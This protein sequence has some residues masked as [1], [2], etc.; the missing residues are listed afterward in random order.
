MNSPV[1]IHPDELTGL[2]LEALRGHAM[3]NL[4][5]LSPLRLPDLAQRIVDGFVRHT[6]H[7]DAR[8]AAEIGR[9]ISSLG[10]ALRSF[11]AVE[12]AL[13][14]ALCAAGETRDD[15]V[16]RALLVADFAAAV[17]FG[18][19]RC[20]LLAVEHQRDTLEHALQEAI[21]QEHENLRRVIRELSTPVVPIADRVL[22]LPLVGSIDLERSSLIME[23]LLSAIVAHR[24]D[25]VIIDLTGVPF[26]EAEV[27]VGMLAVA[28]SARLL[29]AQVIGVGLSP[30]FARS[31][32]SLGVDTSTVL[33]LATVQRGLEHVA[34]TR[35]KR[36]A[37][38]L[39]R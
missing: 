5:T 25:I 10:L 1:E 37:P 24:A 4:S 36:P 19:R 3:E 34:R 17:V 8:S 9:Q 21:K 27:T 18:M 2:V 11:L 30:E 6:V 28:R 13:L 31:L 23:R 15:M 39:L 32:V 38:P 22:L 20:E 14:Q 29:G 33:M 16:T 35:A 7:A 26:I 12:R